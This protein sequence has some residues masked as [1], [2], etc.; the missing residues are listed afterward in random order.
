MAVIIK[1]KHFTRWL[2]PVWALLVVLLLSACGD[3]EPEQRKA[4][5]DYLQNTV[6]RSG[7]NIPTLSEDQKQKFGNYV[8]DYAILV[9]FSQRFS[10]SVET[11]IN[12]VLEQ[13]S[14]I[15]TAQDYIFK[16]ND[17]SQSVGNLNLVEQQILTAKSLADRAQAALK[18]PEELKKIYN[19]VY[20]K[21]VTIPSNTLL[22]ALPSI[23]GFVQ[24]VMQVGAFLQA[25]GTQVSFNNSSVQLRTQQQVTEYN[26]MMANLVA[27]QQ[28]FLNAQQAVK[29]VTQ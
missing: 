29:S 20:S 24:D 1:N 28:N 12:P 10:K 11:G 23:A 17:L 7:V 22:P 6:V 5:I 15:H 26:K 18:Q 27:K 4:F 3:K 19:Q 25:Q 8:N 16:N 2:A 21:S 13:I 14:Q 9:D